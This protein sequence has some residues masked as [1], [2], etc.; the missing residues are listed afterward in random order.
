[1]RLRSTRVSIVAGRNCSG[2]LVGTKLGTVKRALIHRF[3]IR[4]P[5]SGLLVRFQT[6][7][8]GQ[9]RPPGR[10]AG[11]LGLSALAE[12]YKMKL[13]C[14]SK[15]ILPISPGKIAHVVDVRTGPVNATDATYEGFY[16]YPAGSIGP[17]CGEVTLTL[18]SDKDPNKAI[19]KQKRHFRLPR[20]L[21]ASARKEGSFC[22]W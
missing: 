6:P 16:E 20:D 12:F 11:L 7:C 17:S 22:P 19:L 8:F 4:R 18:Y 3:N 2:L 5:P 21:I 13:A 15:E 1:M 9:V 10:E 14:G